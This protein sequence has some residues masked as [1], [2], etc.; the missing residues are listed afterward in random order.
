MENDPT[1]K[2]VHGKVAFIT[3]GG[4]GVGFGMAK[5]FHDAGMKIV[6][7]DIRQDHLD[8]TMAYFN[9]TGR[10]AHPI[11][12]D[13]T[14]REAFSRA[15]DEAERVFGKVHIVCNNAGV[16]FFAPMDECTYE[17]WD[18]LLGVNL[19]GGINGIR[20]FVPRFKKY[21]EWGYIVNTDL[22]ASFSTGPGAGV[23]TTAKF[24]VRGL[25]ESLRGSL[26]LYGIGVSVVCPGLVKSAI[27]E[28]DKIRPP[29]F[30]TD[31]GPANQEFMARLPE[32][33]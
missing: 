19:G 15:A 6:I 28:S 12:L 7:A 16:N 25:S 32:I 1:M 13:V 33:H 14:D 22:I 18:W 27:Y 23:Y 9:E 11:Q 10:K 20:T 26:I 4:S 21:G 31:I 5:A 17:D 24:A 8:R 2:Y 3:G 29:Q 30:S